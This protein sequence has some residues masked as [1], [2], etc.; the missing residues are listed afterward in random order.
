MSLINREK[1][2]VN[3]EKS[4]P[5]IHHFFHR[6]FFTVYVL[7]SYNCDGPASYRAPF[8]GSTERS[9]FGRSK[10]EIRSYIFSLQV[11]TPQVG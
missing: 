7:M 5:K 1:L 4:A 3:R 11:R 9:G 8:Q 2:C 10:F 6:Y